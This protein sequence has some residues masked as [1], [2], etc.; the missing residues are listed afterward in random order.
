MTAL[1][2]LSLVSFP[3]AFSLKNIIQQGKISK[4]WEGVKRTYGGTMV[5]AGVLLEVTRA[6]VNSL[7][8]KNDYF[9]ITPKGK[10]DEISIWQTLKRNKFELALAA[11][12]ISPLFFGA[13][14]YAWAALIGLGAVT[15]PLISWYSNYRTRSENS[16]N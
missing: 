2:W 9:R 5:G 6:C 16:V 1:R 10:L 13:Y 3:L 8:Y 11:T 14:S 15:S 4:F 7:I 12:F